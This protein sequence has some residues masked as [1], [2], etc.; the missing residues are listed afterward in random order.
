MAK[1]WRHRLKKNPKLIELTRRLAARRRELNADKEFITETEK[2]SDKFEQALTQFPKPLN[3]FFRHFSYP[4]GTRLPKLKDF[5][6]SVENARLRELLIQYV[7]Y[8]ARFGAVIRLRNNRPRI[9]VEYLIPWG[10]TFHVRLVKGHFE[11]AKRN[12]DE[13]TPSEY[14]FESETVEM[15]PALRK[16]MK[17]SKVKFVKIDDNKWSSI[18]SKLEYFAYDPSCLTF[19]LHNAEQP[20]LFCLVG[21]KATYDLWKKTGKVV[22]AFTREQFNREK[23]GRPKNLDRFRHAIQLRKQPGQKKQNLAVCGDS[24]KDFKSQQS[25]SARVGKS[26]RT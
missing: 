6:K 14:F 18:L 9:T 4:V 16:Q 12:S 22:T 21:E 7:K 1:D 8:V 26:L 24:E 2:L 13:N 5:L 25:Y 15:P 23:A 17:S 11:P 19:I 10:L 3:A 20:Y